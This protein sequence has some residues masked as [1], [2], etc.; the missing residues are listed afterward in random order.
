MHWKMLFLFLLYYNAQGTVPPRW[1]R[2]M[3]FPSA[4]RV[5]RSSAVL[6]NPVLQKSREDVDLL[7]EFLLGELEIDDDLKIT[8]KD[9]E[10]ASTR[11]A[12]MFDTLCNDV[13]PKSITEIRRLS[14]RLSGYP[15]MLKKEDFERTVLTMVYTAY[16]T[17]QSQGHQKDTWAESFVN[18]YKLLM[19]DLKLLSSQAPTSQ[20]T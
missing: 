12:M 16:R 19:H 7:F 8:V 5:K 15:G 4:H 1:N 6:L 11:K 9:E 20:R 13:I 14:S 2:A 17:A 10:L 18:L 3:F